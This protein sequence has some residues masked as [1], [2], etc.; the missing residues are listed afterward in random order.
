MRSA[1]LLA[2][3]LLAVPGEVSAVPARVDMIARS[4]GAVVQVQVSQ[5]GDRIVAT[6]GLSLGEDQRQQNAAKGISL[7]SGFVIAAEGL[8]VTNAHVLGANPGLITVRLGDGSD[9][10][11]SLVGRDDSTDLAVI[12]L[13]LPARYPVLTWGESQKVRIGE[14]VVAVGSPFGLGGTVTAGIVSGR[15]RVIGSGPFD[16]F[17]QIDAPINQGNSGGP[18][19]DSDGRVIGV[20]TAILAPSGG[21]VGIGFSIPAQVARVVVERLVSQGRVRHGL[22]GIEVQSVSADMADALGLVPPRGVLVTQIVADG[23]SAG[24]DLRAGDIVLSAGGQTIA[25]LAELSALLAVQEPGRALPLQIWRAGRTM[26][27][28]VTPTVPPDVA[29]RRGDLDSF[30]S[31]DART[32]LLG[33]T[34]AA[35]GPLLNEAAGQP[36]QATGLMILAVEPS[37]PAAELGIAAGDLVTSANGITVTDPQNLVKIVD[38][39]RQAGRRNLLLAFAREQGANF[40]AVPLLAGAAANGTAASV[41]SKGV[42]R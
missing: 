16:D 25:G 31:Y 9:R 38:A 40:I 39:A 5:P 1:I 8:I 12:R 30:A 36:G 20:N 6:Q 10:A 11:A 41:P 33:L 3:T 26:A 19:L 37:S 27:S 22:L 13:D 15:G 4:L 2:A 29:A 7:G 21:N 23:P 18:L 24:A 35:T 34:V 17:L 32:Q 28:V 42:I 14:D